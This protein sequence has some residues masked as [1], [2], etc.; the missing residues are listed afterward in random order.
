MNRI[1]YLHR[2]I[3]LPIFLA[4]I[5]FSIP[6][7]GTCVIKRNSMEV[8]PETL[9]FSLLDEM[10]NK[11]L[12]SMVQENRTHFLVDAMLISAICL[13]CYSLFEQHYQ[14]QERFSN[15]STCRYFIN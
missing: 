10:K 6:F 4:F 7:G 9:F 11:N 13:A 14:Q 3:R 1:Y 5:L 15:F 2:S 12:T 8:T